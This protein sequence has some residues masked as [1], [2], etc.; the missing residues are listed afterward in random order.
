MPSWQANVFNAYQRRTRKPLHDTDYNPAAARK[1]RGMGNGPVDPCIEE[2][3]NSGR[4][5]RILYAAGGGFCFP[6][7]P[8]H[9]RF[10]T[11]L[12][13]LVQGLGALA[14]YRLAPESP[15]PGPVTDV[16]ALFVREL[17]RNDA[18]PIVVGGDSAGAN[19]V[20]GALSLIRDEGR[21]LPE[22]CFLFS[23]W[24]DLAMKRRTLFANAASDP[25]FGPAALLHKAYYYL[26]DHD[27]L[28]PLASPL[29]ADLGGLPPLLVQVGSTEVMYDD[30]AA[31][32]D[33]ADKAGVQAR[34][35]V[36]DRM[37]HVFQH[38]SFLPER[39]QAL[40]EVANFIEEHIPQ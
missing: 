21:S 22:A 17:E 27:A 34:L 37:P 18:G 7:G 9:R 6:P 39:R 2:I 31:L 28:D 13:G 36:W 14:L 25:S 1:A 33:R 19:A 24:T 10:L 5:V 11:D 20:L 12:S 29:Y 26:G 35:S 15:F 8:K 40:S 16:A 4:R 32:V 38:L 23:P 3:A 30:S